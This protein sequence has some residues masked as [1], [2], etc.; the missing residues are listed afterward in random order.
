MAGDD[1]LA[2]VRSQVEDGR[3]IPENSRLVI[4]NH[5]KLAGTLTLCDGNKMP[6]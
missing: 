4:E 1:A 5:G 2:I 6:A 3:P